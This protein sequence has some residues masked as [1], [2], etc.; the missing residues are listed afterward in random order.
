M[1]LSQ[2]ER[3]LMEYRRYSELIS[4]MPDDDI[5]IEMQSV[6]NKL[7]TCVSLI[8]KHCLNTIPNKND[9]DSIKTL[10]EEIRSARKKLSSVFGVE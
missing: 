7:A 10:R 3:F 6:L 9:N 4:Q 5:K 8:D 2:N 1:L